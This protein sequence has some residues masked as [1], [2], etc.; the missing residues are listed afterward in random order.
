MRKRYIISKTKK[1][2][3]NEITFV[4][5][6]CFYYVGRS[7]G[8]FKMFVTMH[9]H[10]TKYG[11]DVYFSPWQ[12]GVSDKGLS[13]CSTLSLNLQSTCLCRV[14]DLHQAWAPY[15]K[16]P[17]REVATEKPMCI[18]RILRTAFLAG[19]HST[20]KNGLPRLTILC[21]GFIGMLFLVILSSRFFTW[22]LHSP[23]S[24]V[25]LMITIQVDKLAS[26]YH[27]CG[28]LIQN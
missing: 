9:K 27:S 3:Q 28:T 25:I 7:L 5:P 17:S 22:K 4:K 8:T 13:R 6:H 21:E 24:I 20:K 18:S 19:Q 12:V 15:I 23:F 11:V 14:A 1:N 26:M 10:F 16:G 2:C